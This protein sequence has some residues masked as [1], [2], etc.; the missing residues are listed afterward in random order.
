MLRGTSRRTIN[1]KKRKEKI[2]Q[3]AKKFIIHV[4]NN[5]QQIAQSQI[6]APD[7]SLK[8]DNDPFVEG[9]YIYLNQF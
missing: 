7:H 1:D 8:L 9:I 2:K 5:T 3:D 4:N 6:I